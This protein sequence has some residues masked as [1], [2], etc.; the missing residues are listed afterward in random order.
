MGTQITRATC[1]PFL[2]PDHYARALDII[3][4]AGFVS[5]PELADAADLPL[6]LAAATLR[7]YYRTNPDAR[8]RER[9]RRRYLDRT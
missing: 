7:H 6:H 4:R 1:P 3:V 9:R 8:E 5:A 2:R